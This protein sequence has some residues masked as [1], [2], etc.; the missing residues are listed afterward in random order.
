MVFSKVEEIGNVGKCKIMNFFVSEKRSD[1][2]EKICSSNYVSNI[3]V[4]RVYARHVADRPYNH[5][6]T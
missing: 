3:V 4:I 6:C 5:D 1:R 2:L